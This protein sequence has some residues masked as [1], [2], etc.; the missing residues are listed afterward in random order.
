MHTV[1]VIAGFALIGIILIDAF[2]TIILPRRVTRRLRLTRLFILTTW[3][4]WI[5]IAKMIRRDDP[6]EGSDRRDRFFGVFGPLA[7]LLLLAVWAVGL[8][9]G[10]ALLHWGFGDQ[11]RIAG[12][13]ASFGEIIYMSGTTFFTLG[14]GDVAPVTSG[15]RFLTVAETA[16]GFSF[17]AVTIG[18]LPVI[19]N[20]FA[21][22]EV[23]ITLLDARAG[24]PPSAAELLRRFGPNEPDACETF[25]RDWE[26]WAADVLETHLS[27][28]VLAFFRSQHENQSWLAALTV[29]L[30]ACALVIVGIADEEQN[31]YPARQARITFAMARHAVGDMSQVLNVPPKYNGQDRLPPERLALLRQFLAK[32]H[33][34]L[35]DGGAVD[36]QL[37]AVRRLYEPYVVA[38]GER[39]IFN[40]PPWLPEKGAVDD[41]QTTAWQQDPQDAIDALGP[42]P[43]KPR[44]SG[45][46]SFPV[47][48][49]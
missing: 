38:I 42:Y 40:L 28:P 10:Y 27:Y 25:L 12:E 43:L 49:D 18:Y 48:R 5:G 31:Y 21:S 37:A 16:T 19:Y 35:R 22:R 13:Q 26:R 9:M 41:W 36:E 24:S 15:A 47:L 7:L 6:L 44:P 39:L 23:N 29:I 2:E 20:S 32:S 17:L 4:L 14:L 33:M 46:S 34:P 45:R 30:D 11:L 1:A 3:E 8:V